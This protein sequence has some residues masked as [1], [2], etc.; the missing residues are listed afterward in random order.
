M[1]EDEAT[2]EA[3]PELEAVRRCWEVAALAQFYRV[4]GPS[5]SPPLPGAPKTVEDLEASLV[6]GSEESLLG[7]LPPLLGLDGDVDAGTCWEAVAAALESVDAIGFTCEASPT[8]FASLAPADRGRL[9]YTLADASLSALSRG[10]ELDPAMARGEVLGSDAKGSLYWSLGDRRLYR[11]GLACVGKGKKK[12]GACARSWEVVASCAEDWHQLIHGLKKRGPEAALRV[13]LAERVEGVAAEEAR[14][15]KEAKRQALLAGPRRTSSRV[16]AKEEEEMARAL[17]A[18]AK[19]EQLR[20]IDVIK[21][22]LRPL[23]REL[24]EESDEALVR[25]RL[26]V[27]AVAQLG[28]PRSRTAAQPHGR[29]AAQLPK[30]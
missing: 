19:A 4:V 10:P 22:A 12:R 16:E 15:A 8:S 24:V 9:L 30:G 14:M 13:T 6:E 28:T 7:L 20:L 1:F 2:A 26:P 3:G 11:E 21:S 25:P 27:A 17:A 18:A 29:T 5:L 23:S